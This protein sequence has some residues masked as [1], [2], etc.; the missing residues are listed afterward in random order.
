MSLYTLGIDPGATGAI[1]AVDNDGMVAWTWSLK[2]RT[3]REIID[4]LRGHSDCP[5]V[6]ERQFAMPGQGL[7]STFKIGEGY[8]VLV[9]IVESLGLPLHLVRPQE[10]QKAMLAGEGKASG[11]E[12]KRLYVG[13]AERLWP[14]ISFRGPRGG[15]DDG[16]AAACLIAEYGRRSLA[17]RM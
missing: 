12:L 5:C 4:L 8:G 3:H 7:S 10:W 17:G 16:K 2:G 11:Q 6:V 9:G 13:V 15:M 14:S 1:V